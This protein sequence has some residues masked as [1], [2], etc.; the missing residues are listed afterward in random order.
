MLASLNHPHIARSTASRTAASTRALV[1]EL[2]EG[3][4]RRL[5]ARRAIPL[6][7]AV[8]IALQ[9]AD[10]LEA[11]HE[12]GI[13]HRDLKPANIKITPRGPGESA[14]LRARESADA[15]TGYAAAAHLSQSPTITSPAAMTGAG[16]LL[17]TAPYM[18][19]EQ[20][21]GKMADKR[22]DIWG[23]GCV[24]FE[25]LSGR[26]AF[27]GDTATDTIAH[28]LG[29]DPDWAVL[30]P[31]VP[32]RVRTLLRRCLQK[33]PVR[34]LRDIHDATFELEDAVAPDQIDIASAHTALERRRVGV[35]AAVVVVASVAIWRF[36]P[37][38]QLLGLQPSERSP[39]RSTI[40]G[41][42][43]SHLISVGTG[44]GPA[45]MSS[46]GRRLTFVAAGADGTRRL[47]IRPLGSVLMQPLV[48]TEGAS[49]PFWS[50]NGEQV[51]FFADGK[52]KKVSVSGGNVTTLCDARYA[53]GGSWSSEGTIVF[54]P[55]GSGAANFRIW[56]ISAHGNHFGQRAS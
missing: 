18:S 24:L 44:A 45:V 56:R 42:P 7:E 29:R 52:L 20:A 34:R 9:V 1:L 13:V 14:G 46:D 32:E 11:A 15:R 53:A 26:R 50:P 3:D 12:H 16:M 22:V 27:T 54:A 17:G 43:E 25:M 36:W 33:D 37:M 49:Y 30:P 10:A 47:W 23:F 55:Y 39:V 31:G 6:D 21:R 2:V 40:P 8:P 4:A 38:R 19:P 48:G 5:I 35:T 41:P 28:I 51:G